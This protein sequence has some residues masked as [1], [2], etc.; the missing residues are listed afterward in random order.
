MRPPS[1]VLS[2]EMRSASSVPPWAKMAS[3]ACRRWASI[4][5]TESPLVLISEASFS[6]VSWKLSV[7][8]PVRV[9]I[10]SVMREPVSSSFATT[11]VPRKVRSSTRDSPVALSEL[12]TSSARVAMLSARCVPV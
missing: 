8:L 2:R 6:A 7:T 10:V 11:S 5:L 4:S 1:A 12:F 9:T 3:S